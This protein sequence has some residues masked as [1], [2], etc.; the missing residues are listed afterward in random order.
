MKKAPFALLLSGGALGLT[1]SIP[2]LSIVSWVATIPLFY[3]LA[4]DEPRKNSL[5]YGLLGL[6]SFC[7]GFT[8]SDTVW[9]INFGLLK[10]IKLGT[11][12]ACAL[13]ITLTPA[14]LSSNYLPSKRT[15]TY[16]LAIS[17]WASL[18]ILNQ[19]WPLA[20]PLHSIGTTL[21]EYPS[22]VNWYEITGTIGGTILLL[23]L[24]AV[25]A[26]A[27]YRI[28]IKAK[29]YT[30]YHLA[31]IAIW[32]FLALGSSLSTNSSTQDT[33][34]S[35]AILHP[36]LDVRGERR[37]FTQSETVSHYLDLISQQDQRADNI[38]AP[39]NVILDGG[40]I[41]DIQSGNIN[42]DLSTVQTKLGELNATLYIGS[43][44]YQDVTDLPQRSED[45]ATPDGKHFF[46]AFNVILEISASEVR[47][48]HLKDRLVPF[49]EFVPFPNLLSN[50]S[51]PVGGM[52][53][54]LS[55]DR[56]LTNGQIEKTEGPGHLICYES[57]FSFEV[58]K[59]VNEKAFNLLTVHLNEGW[60]DSF[61]GARKFNLQGVAR[62]IET[63]RYVIRSSNRGI[64]SAI[65]NN[66]NILESTH[67][68]EA[69]V[70]FINAAIL[71]NQTWFVKTGHSLIPKL[72]LF[73]SLGL[74]AFAIL[75]TQRNNNKT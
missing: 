39:E 27:I 53:F 26:D 9:T 21:S 12:N 70:L 54:Y 49:E 74:A 72:L 47:I 5:L 36:N 3:F 13:C 61:V 11:A 43:F 15:L 35:F 19:S 68:K 1:Q 58:A 75:T 24:S 46:R 20:Y 14:L 48:A 55:K 16:S 71:S 42:R 38:I 22:L 52:G 45:N 60:Y 56:F 34:Q 41:E 37:E 18:E 8:I 40:F 64:T 32:V 73:L 69:D 7:I 50:I 28:G 51:K 44:V 6:L 66:G 25:S 65:D 57:A 62:A 67:K 33:K 10:F 2:F 31:P 17:G 29:K 30:P 63:N 4:K 23:C 59:R